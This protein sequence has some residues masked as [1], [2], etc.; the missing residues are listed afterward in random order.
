LVLHDA[1]FSARKNSSYCG[2]YQGGK[3]QKSYGPFEWMLS[4]PLWLRLAELGVWLLGLRKER[5]FKPQLAFLIVAG[6]W[7]SI[8]IQD[9]QT[10]SILSILTKS[11]VTSV[12]SYG[13]STP[14]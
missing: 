14:C 10:P 1:N 7:F 6:G 11:T 4:I 2:R 3:Q 13:S 8:A 9:Y 5:F 12:V